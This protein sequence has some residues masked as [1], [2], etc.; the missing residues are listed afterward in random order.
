MHHSRRSGPICL[1][2]WT[3]STDMQRMTPLVHR[4]VRTFYHSKSWWHTEYHA[5]SDTAVAVSSHDESALEWAL[6]TTVSV[7]PFPCRFSFMSESGKATLLHIGRL[8]IGTIVEKNQ[9]SQSSKHRIPLGSN[10]TDT[11]KEIRQSGMSSDHRGV[12]GIGSQDDPLLPLNDRPP[13]CIQ[14]LPL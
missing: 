8:I 14:K 3:R 6:L 4:S 10:R 9:L 11:F 2:H 7:F 12:R 1:K 5:L 13:S